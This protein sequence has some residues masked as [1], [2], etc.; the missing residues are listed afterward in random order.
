MLYAGQ[1]ELDR[2]DCFSEMA[3]DNLTSGTDLYF[4]LKSKQY[5]Q[6]YISI[7]SLCLLA[8]LSLCVMCLFIYSA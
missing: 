1:V 2:S 6:I 5:E 8:C 4:I 7:Y 3:H